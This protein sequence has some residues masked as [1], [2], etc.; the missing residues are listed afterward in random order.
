MYKASRILLVI[1]IPLL[2]FSCKKKGKV[3]YTVVGAITDKTFDQPAAS[4]SIDVYATRDASLEFTL[5]TSTNTDANGNYGFAFQRDLYDKIKVVP[6]KNNYFDGE[7]TINFA[8]LSVEK[9][10]VRN[11]EIYAKSWAKII[12]SNPGGSP[13]DHLSYIKQTGKSDCDGCCP[14]TENHLYGQYQ[15]TIVCINNGNSNYS[16]LYNKYTAGNQGVETIS[17]IAFDTTMLMF[18]H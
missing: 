16:F 18:T 8:D 17:T 6:K 11:G 4:V 5:L 7:F 9:D 10:N 15:D 3:E 13:S 1:G 14:N 2:L 12:F